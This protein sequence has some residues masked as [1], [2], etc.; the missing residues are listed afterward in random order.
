MDML[1]LIGAEVLDESAQFALNEAVLT[2]QRLLNAIASDADFLTKVT[3]AFGDGFDAEKLEGLRQQWAAS[4]FGA[5][6]AIEIRSSSEINGANGAFSADTNTIY[7]AKEYIAQNSSN[8]Q[9]IADVLLEEIG[10]SVDSKINVLDA[11]GDEGAI[12]SV[13]AQGM[14]L[15]ELRFQALKTEDDTAT[16]TLDG[17]VIQ[18]EQADGKV[19]ISGSILWK[20]SVKVTHPVRESTVEIWDRKTNTLVTTLRTQSDGTYS[21]SFDNN[22]SKFQV[23]D[24]YIKVFAN[25][26][27]HDIYSPQKLIYSVSSTGKPTQKP[28]GIYQLDLPIGN[29]QDAE[30]AFSISDALYTAEKY[31][32]SVRGKAD[33]LPTFFP[34]NATNT[35]YSPG[36]LNVTKNRSFNWDVLQHEYGHFLTE[37]DALGINFFPGLGQQKLPDHQFGD[38]NIPK[39]QKLTPQQAKL[40]GVR[41]GWLEGLAT[42]LGSAA[43][44]V[45]AN[46]NNLPNVPNVNDL[47]YTTTASDNSEIYF[48]IE[49]NK[50]SQAKDAQGNVLFDFSRNQGEGDEASVARILWDIADDNE[51]TF[52]SGLKDEI[53]LGHKELYDIFKNKIPQNSPGNSLDQIDDVWNYFFNISKDAKRTQYGAI[54]EEYGVSPSP[55]KFKKKFDAGSK[56]PTFKWERNNNDAN[57]EFQVIVFNK[58]FSERLLDTMA[59]KVK[60]DKGVT[61]WQPT[62]EQWDKVI[63]NP[64]EYHFIVAGSDTDTT[65]LTTGSYWSGARNFSVVSNSKLDSKPIKDGL[66][67]IL[68][69]IGKDLELLISGLDSFFSQLQGDVNSQVLANKLPLLGSLNSLS[70]SSLN[71]SLS[72]LSASSLSSSLPPLKFITEIHDAILDKLAE[73]VAE[74]LDPIRDVLSV[75]LG[76][77]LKVPEITDSQFKDFLGKLLDQLLLAPSQPTEEDLIKAAGVALSNTFKITNVQN[78]QGEIKDFLVELQADLTEQ[79]NGVLSQ[80]FK[81]IKQALFNAVGPSGINILKDSNSNGID[82]NDIK[83]DITDGVKFDLNLGT[84]KTFSTSLATDIGFSGLGLKVDGDAQVDFDFNLDLGFGVNKTDGFFLDTSKNKELSINLDASLPGLKATGELGFLQLDVTDKDSS[85]KAGFSVDLKDK[86]S[87][88]K[89]TSSELTSVKLDTKLDLAADVNLGLVTSFDGSAKLPSISSDFNLD[90]SFK[91]A[92]ADPT[93]TLGGDN[94]PIIGFNNVKLDL[95]TFISDFASP[96]LKNV[97]KITKPVKPIIDILEKDIDLKVA[98]FNLL[99]IAEGLGYIDQQDRDFIDSVSQVVTIVNSIP[100][101]KSTIQIALGSFNLGNDADIRDPQFKLSNVK[102][103]NITETADALDDQLSGTDKQ[104][105]REFI[106]KLSSV[107]GGGLQFPILTDPK[108]A[109]NLLLGKDVEL[110]TYD[111]PKLEFNLEYS[112]FFPIV[113]PLGARIGGKIGAGVDLAFGYDTYGLRQFIDT[114]KAADI[115]NGF[116]VSDRAN[117]DGTGAD[118]PEVTLN[119]GLEASAELNIVIASAGVGGGIYGNIDF[120]LNDPNNDGKVRVNEFAALIEENPLCIFDT[121]GALTAGLNAYVKFGIKPFQI[122]KRFNSP[123]ITIAEFNSECDDSH[124]GGGGGGG[125]QT[126][127]PILATDLGSGVLRLN[128]GPNAANRINR[129]TIDGEEIFTV[130]HQS[131]SSGNE[132]LVISAFDTRE[133]H[134]GVSKIVANGGEKDDIIELK[135]NVLTP[136]ELAG[137]NGDDLVTGGSGNDSLEGGSGFDLL[138]GRN[139]NDTLR[140]GAEDDWLIGGAGAD[141]LDGGDGDDTASYETATTGILLNLATGEATGDAKGDVFL[142]IEQYEGSLHD[143]TLI[144]DAKDNLLGGLGGN[145][146][147]EGGAGND[148][149]DGGDGND[150]LRGGVGNDSLVGGAGADVLDGGEGKDFVSYATASSGIL[151]NLLTGET[152]GDAAGDVFLSIEEIEGSYYAD[153]LVGDATNNILRGAGG[154]DSVEGGAGNDTLSGD[155]GDDSLVGGVGADV[156]NGGDGYDIASYKT[157]TT[158]VSINLATGLHTGDAAGDVFQSIEEIE[159]SSYQDTFRG[160]T[161]N[162]ILSGADGDDLLIGGGGA[163]TL[164]GGQGNDTYELDAQTAAGSKIQDIGGSTDTLN[165]SNITLSLSTPVAGKAGLGRF[166]NALIIDINQDGKAEQAKDLT[167]ENFFSPRNFSINDVTLTEAN[168]GITNAVFKVSATSGTGSGG[169]GF[170]EKVDNL[171]GSDILSFL[172]TV[173]LNYTTANGTATAGI[174]YNPTSGQLTFTES[175][176]QKTITVEVKGDTLVEP[177]ETFFVNL[178]NAS[179]TDIA[180]SQGKG[181]IKNDDT[182]IS[183]SD[184]TVTEGNGGLFTQNPKAVFTV[185]L[186]DASKETVT[187]DFETQSGTASADTDYKP[188][189]GKVIFKPGEKEKTITVEVK[190]DK[191][192]ENDETFFVNLTNASNANI[193]DNQGVGTIRNDDFPV[194]NFG[195]PSYS[196]T[197]GNTD[198]I[199][200]IPVTLSATPLTD[201]TVPIAINPS[202]TATSGATK[203]YTLSAIS[204]TFKAGAT[205]TALTQ[206][207]AVTIKP[208]NIAENNETIVLNFGTITG[209]KAGKTAATTL[210]IGANDPI[211]YAISAGAASI[212]E[213]NSGSTPITFTV[214]RSGGTDA[215]SSINYAIGG[216][217]TNGSDY[218]NISGTSGATGTTGTINF[219]AGETSKTITMNVLGDTLVEPNET[220]TVNLSSPVAPGPTP[221]I[222]TTAAT[223][224]ILND[225]VAPATRRVSVASDGIQGNSGSGSHSISADG[226]YVAFDSYASNLVS[227]DTNSTGDI[228]IKDL[229][230]GTTKR[231]SVASDGTQGNNDSYYPSISADGRY[232]AFLSSATNLVS[233]DTNGVNDIFVKD[234]Q[235][236]TTKRISVASD[237]TQGNDQSYNP[238]NPSNPSIS[239]DGRYVTFNS[240]ATNLVS[241]DTNGAP[242]I[243]VKDLQTGTTKRI[244]VASDGTQGNDGSSNPS[245]SPDGRYVAFSSGA[246]NLVSGDTNGVNDIFV[247][248][249]QTGTTRRISVAS[250]GTQ[251]NDGS[252]GPSI[253]A[254]GR[255]VAFNSTATNLVSGD[256]NGVNDIFVKD[257]QTGTTK[258]ISVASD[259][260]QGNDGSSNPSIS[261][262]GRYVAF[263]SFASNLVS[264]D[265]NNNTDIFVKDL[266]TGTTKRISVAS[267]GTQG[268][269]YSYISSI[270]ADGRYVAF[271]SEARNLVSGDTNNATDIFVHDLS[272]NNLPV[273]NF[274]VASYSGTEG[275]SDTV[276]NI[277]VTLSTTPL[278]D[279]TVPIAINPN[280]TATSGATNDYTLSATSLTFKAGATGAALTQ[281]VAVTIKPDNIAENAETVVLNLGTITGAIAGTTA[282]TTVTIA[283]NDP[284]AYA[285]S[286]G[287]ATVTEGNSGS[288]PITFTVSRSGGTDVASS[289]NYA[290]GGTATNGSDYNNIGGTSGAKSPTGTINFAAGETSKTITMNVLGDT[291]VEPNETITVSLSS[292]VAPGPTPTITTTAA[293]TTIVNDDVPQPS[294][295]TATKFSV[296]SFPI[297]VAMTDLN[298][299]GKPDLAVTNYESNNV[300]ILLGTGGGS[301]GSP[302]NFSVGPNPTSVA[303]GDLN[304]DNKPD[305]VVT[306]YGSNNVSILLGAGTGSFSP[307][308]NFSVG[309]QPYSVAVGDL[310]GDGKPDLAVANNN[311]NNVSILLGTGGGSFGP[312]TNFGVGSGPFSI[313]LGDFNKDSKPDLAVANAISDNVSILLGTGGGSFGPATNFSAGDGSRSI[314]VG[315]FNG[316]SKP[317]LATANIFSNNVSILL[318]TGGGSFGPATNFSAGS[319]PSSV[320]VGDF[321][322]D[323]KPDLAVTSNNSN[324]VSI[325]FGA[326][327]GS[328]GPATNFSAGS[329]QQSVAVGDLNGD[330]K[331]DLAT[332]NGSS[333]NISILLNTSPTFNNAPLAKASLTAVS[334]SMTNTLLSNESA[335]DGDGGGGRDILIGGNGGDILVGD[336]SSARLI[337]GSGANQFTFNSPTDGIDTISDFKVGEGD[338]IMI[339]ASGFGGGLAV[340]NLPSSQFT[341]GSSAT[342]ASDRFIYNSSTG[343]L[344]FDPDGN[345]LQGQVQLAVLSSNPALTSSNIFVVV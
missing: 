4:D 283:A 202:S 149:L 187:V 204:L 306:N 14:Q 223:T 70:S 62:K 36:G 12:F 140:G 311:S 48:N 139:G 206:N 9:A 272:N 92:K 262:D 59:L 211:A 344:F 203:D 229:Q 50:G 231:I 217:A 331:P 22:D 106:T 227:G 328:F 265:T 79:L 101:N 165:L 159:G 3:L 295:T 198:T 100:T 197:E 271:I 193:V 245:I 234:L 257:L 214:S 90:W 185:S 308:T 176:T 341:I 284:I 288:T 30:Q 122:K 55:E 76:D 216:T 142:S 75:T 71:N 236:G 80:P 115:F 68:D 61:K 335:P 8:P 183:I 251:G 155:A 166:G 282:T 74:T 171:S 98:K 268:N 152:K 117:P 317:D 158:G 111:L 179:N 246:S 244:S 65:K 186:S 40:N 94:K 208:D 69:A 258:R 26:L 83:L 60:L 6:P 219:A 329:G 27:Y 109:F 293:T 313:A 107:P 163:D 248:D 112:Q 242:D 275:N 89:L 11:P 292:P 213:G 287:S 241:G 72:S 110:F 237:G 67:S 31:A 266:Q 84:E 151:I 56:I 318:G 319:Q 175:E 66:G 252:S 21:A 255:Y 345:G 286:A 168:N 145:D 260:T 37:K 182:L 302:S 136:A 253:S 45:T 263:T 291:L 259:G 305:L 44:V 343:A 189:K 2:A 285:I 46:D 88:G 326:G 321:N 35:S 310:N 274:N 323:S 296:G 177:D 24:I 174:D 332:A 160:D 194:V 178:T 7:L 247:K 19:T 250:D 97:Q 280:S 336:P 153:T 129:N 162:N 121:S 43:Q 130:E 20:D 239:A 238:S 13:L 138:D 199:V 315:D 278:T 240:S 230:T 340:G 32:I 164:R 224:T 147:L 154:N 190:G 104:T 290:I 125:T 167:I 325:L 127:P 143:D 270:S 18:I 276:I 222:T 82:I 226:R 51:D 95:G 264:G 320:A 146:K 298:A 157:A 307:A 210:T 148:V 228:F 277:P 196:S 1:S 218:N 78:I 77:V 304:G 128:M 339:S 118:V 207:V 63:N 180:K 181:T 47:K 324:N 28:D 99:D 73:V 144:G 156:L 114:K 215:A 102:E 126:P 342:N 105:E 191:N 337:G 23:E 261:A 172:P 338:Q 134:K 243:F 93:K 309:A 52:A 269:S 254:D 150:T 301:F 235:T 267:D 96:V 103:P 316:D 58:D 91:N 300:S 303:V 54:F 86:N 124:S 135:D 116:Y 10:H 5:I 195:A 221:T 297:S 233:G 170:I 17:Q 314:A 200:N 123:R 299:D 64:G 131:G 113:G 85:L 232:V 188:T 137:G 330:S 322:G 41:L 119:A 108:K 327:G 53:G 141:T 212:T 249:L 161:N 281:N 205:G 173:A 120:N 39:F 289:I 57:D 49:N 294:F 192:I 16:I 225:D 209:A 132:T 133:E 29:K 256:T 25:S 42:Y 184:A 169:A 279:V 273:V 38:S 220:I 34:V 334:S 87:D 15:D 333:N 201:V 312:A 81:P 33:S